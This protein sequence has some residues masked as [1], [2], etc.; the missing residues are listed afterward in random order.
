MK[1]NFRKWDKNSGC[2]SNNN[3]LSPVIIT[4]LLQFCG[5]EKVV[6]CL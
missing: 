6:S 3:L 2:T 1:N 4:L 5:Y